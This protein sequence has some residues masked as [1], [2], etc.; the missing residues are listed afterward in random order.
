MADVLPDLELADGPHPWDRQD[1]EPSKDYAAF[2][3]FRDLPIVNRRLGS[4][5]G[6]TGMSERRA[7]EVARRWRWQERAEAWD[8]AVH[9]AEDRERLEAIRQ[10]HQ[11]HRAAGRAAITKALAGLQALSVSELTPATIA[12]LLEL[13]AKLERSTL[14]VSV[15]ELQ[16]IEVEDEE[17]EDAW[18]RIAR[19]LDPDYVDNG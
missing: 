3:I 8:E 15:E 16:G 11:V 7:Q 18:E 9:H 12:R 17:S 5:A 6:Q 2:R 19:A 1:G 10:M 13:G 4:V 14:T